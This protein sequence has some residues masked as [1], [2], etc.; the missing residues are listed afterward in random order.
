VYV[1]FLRTLDF[2]TATPEDGRPGRA[3]AV[4]LMGAAPAPGGQP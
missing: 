3:A 2:G 1:S 4:A